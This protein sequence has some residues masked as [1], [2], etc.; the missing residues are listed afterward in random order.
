[1]TW[2]G[3]IRDTT[4]VDPRH[5]VSEFQANTRMEVANEL[6]RRYGFQSTAI[7]KQNG[8][9]LGI[10]SAD[11]A[12]GNF[13]SFLNGTA[14]PTSYEVQG[15]GPPPVPPRPPPKKKKP[16]VGDPVACTIW[17]PFGDSGSVTGG[18]FPYTLPASSC[19]GTL[20]VTG[21]EAGGGSGGGSGGGPPPDNYGYSFTATADGV[22]FLTSGCLISDSTFASI[23]PG[24][25]NVTVTVTTNCAGGT[26][27]GS[28][29]ISVTSP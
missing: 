10:A 3:T 25:L 27:P 29:S 23:P 18:A 13:Y 14:S 19:A 26:T 11:C 8:P 6:Q 17:G 15:F 5:G 9:I 2:L 24:T 28:W 16:I 4:P 12:S 22:P 7:A 20:T 1:M 21:A